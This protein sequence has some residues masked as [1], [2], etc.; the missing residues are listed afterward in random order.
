MGDVRLALAITCEGS[1]FAA[2]CLEV[3]VTSQGI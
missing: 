3:E 2:H 1:W